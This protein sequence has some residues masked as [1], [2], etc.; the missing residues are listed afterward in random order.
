MLVNTSLSIKA[1]SAE[2]NFEDPP[3]LARFFRRNTGMLSPLEYRKKIKCK[4]VPYRWRNLPYKL[5]I[6]LDTMKSLYL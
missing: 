3:Y 4:S 1:I 2:L 5:K 6:S